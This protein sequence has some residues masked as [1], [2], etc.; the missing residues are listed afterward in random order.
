MVSL[1]NTRVCNLGVICAVL[2]MLWQLLVTDFFN[3]SVNKK[4]IKSL[5]QDKS[6]TNR[7]PITSIE[8]FT[9]SYDPLLNSSN[10]FRM[11]TGVLKEAQPLRWLFFGDSTMMMTVRSSALAAYLEHESRTAVSTNPCLNENFVCGHPL[12]ADRC[13]RRRLYYVPES[14]PQPQPPQQ[15]HVWV[16]P[17]ISLGEGPTAF[18]LYHPDCSDCGGCLTGFAFCRPKPALFKSIFRNMTSKALDVPKLQ[19]YEGYDQSSSITAHAPV[20]GGYIMM[21]FARDVEMQTSQ[22]QTTQEVIHNWMSKV[23]NAPGQVE[24][25]GKPVCVMLAGFHD[26]TIPNMTRP[27]FLSNVQWML[28]LFQSECKHIIW[29]ANSAP[30]DIGS[31]VQTKALTKEWNDGVQD[32]LLELQTSSSTSSLFQNRISFVDVFNASLKSA[33][34]SDTDNVHMSPRFYREL[35]SMFLK[36]MRHSRPFVRY[37]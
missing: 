9:C 16:R 35:G 32:L 1:V 19:C 14:S 29:L 26:M 22:F 34:I 8:D 17:N 10:C 7:M 36:V 33:R 12:Q 13:N 30:A 11:L 20:H 4:I 5:A 31:W 25:F 21:E 2:V 15:Q 24:L 18:G 37:H 6:Q 27:M 28:E 3:K 23:Y